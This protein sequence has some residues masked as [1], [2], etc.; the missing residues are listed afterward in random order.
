MGD[1]LDEIIEH[2]RSEDGGHLW[3]VRFDS[4]DGQ[5]PIGVIAG[6]VENGVYWLTEEETIRVMDALAK[7]LCRHRDLHHA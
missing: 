3:E 4:R 5:L 6:D 2:F 1:G 7:A